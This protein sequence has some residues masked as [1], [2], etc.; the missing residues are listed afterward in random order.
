MA[1]EFSE[2]SIWK[3][4]DLHIHSPDSVLNNEFSSWEDYLDAIEGGDE[5]IV[6]IGITDYCSIEGYKKVAEEKNKKCRL[7]K[8]DLILPNIEFRI[9]PKP[10]NGSGIN[11]HVLVDP[12]D[13]KHI[14]EI[15][16]ALRLLTFQF[17]GNP[18]SCDRGGLTN[19]GRA[20]DPSKTEDDGAY[21][22][23]V[24]QFKP[25][26]QDFKVWYEK[27]GWLKKNSL[28]AVSNS[29]NDGVSGITQDS[30][31]KATGLEILR[32]S[33]I[34]L[35]GNPKD[36]EFFLGKNKGKG[37]EETLIKIIN[38][39]KPC[40]HGSD[41][42]KEES[43][44]KPDLD[45]FCWIKTE[46]PTFDGLRQVIYE[47]E[48]RIRIQKEC[49][50]PGKS[51]YTISKFK[52]KN[53]KDFIDGKKIR[54]NKN[55]V[56]II[57]G[58]GSG[59]TALVDLVANCFGKSCRS[60]ELTGKEDPNSFV[61]RLEKIPKDAL[62]NFK[63]E[64]TTEI[65]FK[66]GDDFEKNIFEEK[67]FPMSEVVYL[68]QGKIESI[69]SDER[70]LDEFIKEL[71]FESKNIKGSEQVE[72]FE[73][74]HEEIDGVIN[75]IND[76][77]MEISRL[78]TAISVDV[79][80]DLVNRE[81][82][83]KG[84]IRDNKD[85]LESVLI[86]LTDEEQKKTNI[87][88]TEIHKLR[89]E[90]D[91]FIESKKK[92]GNIEI[93]MGV[94]Q[95]INIELNSLR[96]KLK[97]TEFSKYAL[98][99]IDIKEQ[100][101]D[102]GKLKKELSLKLKKL[103]LDLSKKEKEAEKFNANEKRH[104]QLLKEKSQFGEDYKKLDLKKKEIDRKKKLLVG[105][106]NDRE[107]A[108]EELFLKYFHIRRNYSLI[109]DSFFEKHEKILEGIKFHSTV[110]FDREKFRS[111]GIDPTDGIVNSRKINLIKFEEL[112]NESSLDFLAGGEE[113]KFLKGYK[114]W[115]KG[116]KSEINIWKSKCR[117]NIDINSFYGWVFGNHL[118]IM[119]KILFDDMPME[120][121]SIGQKGTVVLK[122]Y[123]AEGSNPIVLDQPEDNLDNQFIVKS[124]VE[125]FRYAKKNR[126]IIITTHNANLVVN[127]D[128]EQV[129]KA[130]YQGNKISYISGGM[131]NSQIRRSII[132]LLEGG[133]VAFKKREQKYSL[134]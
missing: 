112:I 66:S 22:E 43:L 121:L 3:R 105:K 101:D 48:E 26:F 63:K 96:S 107:G 119:T 33:D 102:L 103:R 53:C 80:K 99:E 27:Q 116:F 19:L 82:L 79:I 59:K 45:R 38:G 28:I 12:K 51:I 56:A 46:K 77:N 6:A 111:M 25:S 18:Y 14:E 87:L 117:K 16:S 75:K 30:G 113:D 2:G 58:K 127:T 120:K 29:S 39:R 10:K 7:P 90:I 50:E 47:P 81:K 5:S 73:E 91:L 67:F 49:P 52:I 74:T 55:M 114:F 35:S 115:F 60:M 125:A 109:I 20:C 1:D 123:L 124:L 61:Q 131:E 69:C 94:I 4:W 108:L 21:S 32:F 92:A 93:E 15:E 100:V 13:H 134:S 132:E 40:L 41:A 44:F 130:D 24:N 34:I 68:P 57:G 128:A 23:G 9:T 78:E 129:I 86:K 97:K 31:F 106:E 133:E 17:D 11:I 72:L 65:S 85:H 83:I 36:N 88:Q 76:L 126:Q 98:K 8:I 37:D 70:K 71:I 54:F 62:E 64:M 42:H 95:E 118:S 110:L 122:I 104:A 84:K 89:K